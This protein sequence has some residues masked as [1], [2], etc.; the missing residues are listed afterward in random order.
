MVNLTELFFMF[1][2]WKVFSVIALSFKLFNFLIGIFLN[3]W[4]LDDLSWPLVSPVSEAKRWS[5]QDNA[6]FEIVFIAG[7]K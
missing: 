6:H 3:F 5:V 1:D 4:P 7:R 2:Y